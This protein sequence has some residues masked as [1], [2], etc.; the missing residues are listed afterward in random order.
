M[1]NSINKITQAAY[2]KLD[3]ALPKTTAKTR[4]I[5]VD[6]DKNLDVLSESIKKINKGSMDISA[7]KAKDADNDKA[8]KSNIIDLKG[9]SDKMNEILKDGEELQ[10]IDKENET[11]EFSVDKPTKK[12]IMKVIDKETNEIVRQYP[13]EIS[14]KIARIIAD[15]MGNGQFANAQA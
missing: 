4:S 14:L 12:M 15:T 1:V 11:V 5:K 3:E 8:A 6:L 13:P 7:N 10:L 9:I 2:Q